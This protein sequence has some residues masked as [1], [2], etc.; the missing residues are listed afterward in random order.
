M[1]F[2]P[3]QIILKNRKTVLIR[4]AAISDAENLLNCIKTYIPTSN[5][6]PKLESEVTLTVDQEKEWINSFLVNDNSLLLVAEYE[7]KIIGNIDATGSR[8][9]I[10]EHT[11][12]IGMG[13]LQEWQNIGL[14]TAFLS[15]TIEWA[16]NNPIL[17]LLWL[18]VYTDN[19]LGV[20]LYQKMG[21]VANGIIPNFFKQNNTY[22]DNLTMTLT[23]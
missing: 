2:E 12:V 16:R 18:Q 6:I 15:A 5:F 8:R 4:Q 17:E 21:F 20:Q 9:K 7:N 11:A 10:M 23:V 19:E 22:F 14:G 13:M 1:K 3:K